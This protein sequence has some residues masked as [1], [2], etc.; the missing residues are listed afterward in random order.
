M[1]KDLSIRLLAATLG[2]GLVPSAAVAPNCGRRRRALRMRL[3]ERRNTGTVRGLRRGRANAFDH[4]DSAWLLDRHRL[5]AHLARHQHVDQH[6]CRLDLFLPSRR[7]GQRLARDGEP[8]Q[9]P[10]RRLRAELE[11]AGPRP[12]TARTALPSTYRPRATRPPTSRDSP[13]L[14]STRKKAAR[15]AT[16]TAN[17]QPTRLPLD[18]YAGQSIYVAFVNNSYDKNILCLDERVCNDA[19]VPDTLR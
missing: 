4:D 10:R 15:R 19:P 6:L 9:H 18:D 2:L 16:P 11:L 14:P 8:H 17:G 12:G 7:A 3:S 1:K 13:S 5:A